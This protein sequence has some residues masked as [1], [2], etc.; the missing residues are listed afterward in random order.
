MRQPHRPQLPPRHQPP[1]QKCCARG[2]RGGLKVLIVHRIHGLRVPGPPAIV[3]GRTPPITDAA[4]DR[5]RLL[6]PGGDHQCQAV[7]GPYHGAK[8]SPEGPKVPPGIQVTHR[9]HRIACVAQLVPSHCQIKWGKGH[10]GLC[11]S[12]GDGGEAWSPEPSRTPVHT[13]RDQS[14]S[15]YL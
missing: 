10:E 14:C 9:G 4:V 1:S 7:V 11:S 13:H 15:T 5:A 2:A 12:L 6:L 8:V 3:P